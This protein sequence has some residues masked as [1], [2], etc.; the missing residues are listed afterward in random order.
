MKNIQLR[1]NNVSVD[2]GADIAIQL[3]K[4]VSEFRDPLK[5]TGTYSLTIVL[6]YTE[7]N[8]QVF[9]GEND[10]QLL[11]KFRKAYPAELVVGG[12]VLIIGEFLHLKNSGKGFEGSVGQT[13]VLNPKLGDLLTTKKLT[14]IKSFQP[15]A[16]SGDQSVFNSWSG[17]TAY[18]DAEICYPWVARSFSDFKYGFRA[19]YEDL[20]ISHFVAAITKN[21]FTDAGYEVDGAIFQ[22]ST[23]QKLVLL[24][25]SSA[26]QM[27]NYGALAPMRSECNVPT[28]SF[29]GV[30]EGGVTDVIERQSDLI[31]IMGYPF[32][33]TQ[34]DQCNSLGSDGVYTCKFSGVYTV[35]VRGDAALGDGTS[36]TYNGFTAFRDISSDATIPVTLLPSIADFATL[37]NPQYLDAGTL[38]VGNGAGNTDMTFTVRLEEGKQY[39]VQR[40][41]GVPK[42]VTNAG[43]L[44]F[45]NPNSGKFHI[46]DVVGPDTVNPAL[47]LPDMTQADFISAV[48]KIF[49]LYYQLNQEQKTVTLLTRDEF[50]QETV[51][52]VVDLTPFLNVRAMDDI[53]LTSAEIGKTYLSYAG[54]DGDHILKNTDYLDIV[55]GDQPDESTKLPFAPVGFIQKPLTM[56]GSDGTTVV[57]GEDLVPAI[58]PTQESEDRSVL[59]DLQNATGG[60]SWTPRLVLY[61]GSDWLKPSLAS[62]GIGRLHPG[63]SN[64]FTGGQATA[65][66]FDFTAQ[67]P[68]LGF[69]DV[70]NQPA[71]SITE[72]TSLRSFAL[73]LA[74]GNTLYDAGGNAEFLVD[75]TRIPEMNT[76][77]LATNVSSRVNPLGFFYRLYSNDLLIGS[78]SNYVEGIGRMNPVLFTQLNGRQVLRLNSD[79]YF[80]ESLKNYDVSKEFAVYR[81]YRLIA[82]TSTTSIATT[83][84]TSTQSFTA[85][86]GSGYTGS[87]ATATVVRTSFISQASADASALAAATAQ[88]NATIVCTVI[89]IT[90]TSTQTVTVS[91]DYGYSGNDS[92]ATATATSTIDQAD[93]DALANAQADSDAR[94]GLN[95]T[96]ID[97]GP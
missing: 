69:F 76:V 54:D 93:A 49:N 61:H 90:Y 56:L 89:P 16:F 47:F 39:A 9:G 95:C 92:T 58:L 30:Y 14:E 65:A 63:T 73:T 5:K 64:I 23:F 94:A 84:Y 59:D 40:Y 24:Y 36:T 35:T 12:Q 21:I 18:P 81:M 13:K 34:G 97:P 51:N 82:N 10:K 80:L 29:G 53:P 62:V 79:L 4:I 66:Y 44:F 6:P 31:H 38:A 45:Y 26:K 22:N 75:V 27:W 96:Y 88:A 42:T 19:T 46:T 57:S 50:F 37:T 85:T 28:L 8:I 55:N 91:C 17:T 77:S 3:D 72:N 70:G 48:F 7:K 41:I 68:K 71:Y 11:G 87:D 15:V 33:A 60:G 32:H 52:D 86:C 25:S 1:I 74:T 83:R 43:T 2:F 78:L 20:G 67:A